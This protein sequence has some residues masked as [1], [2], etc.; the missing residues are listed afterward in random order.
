M[1]SYWLVFIL[2]VG[3]L[4]ACSTP[5][6]SPGHSKLETQSIFTKNQQLG[7]G[8]N[9]GNYLD[10][11]NYEGAWTGGGVI[12]AY[13]F[14]K[15]KTAGFKSI[16][17][18]V[19]WTHHT[20]RNVPYTINETFFKR[21]DWMLDQ[22]TQRG[23]NI[24]VNVHHYDELNASPQGEEARYLAMWQQIANRYKNRGG[25]VY[26]ELLN[27]PHG[28]FNAN[29]ELWNSLLVKALN[30]VRQTNPTRPVIIG[31]AGWNGIE[32]LSRLR[33]PNDPNIIATVHFYSPFNF[34]AQGF[35]GRPRGVNWS[36]TDTFPSWE[37][38]SWN[39][40]LRSV[41]SGKLEVTFQE[42]NAGF[43]LNTS[44]AARNYTSLVINTNQAVSFSVSCSGNNTGQGDSFR[45]LQT[46]ANEET[47]FSLT[48]CSSITNLKMSNTT[49]AAKT[50][51]IS[52]LELRDSTR[53][54]PL[55]TTAGAALQRQLDIAK[56]W[57]DTTGHPIFL[58][59]FG[60]SIYTA[61]NSRVR[62]TSYV[63]SEAEKRGF[64]W[65]Y[66]ALGANYDVFDLS[67]K[68]WNYTLLKALIP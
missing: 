38:W 43:Y 23:L 26:F 7:R 35:D 49:G 27:E 36:S 21:V 18:P 62:W 31:P 47:I 4:V 20:S 67:R 56:R 34:T 60:T 42:A 50:F 5:T 33:L 3:L 14:D 66:W 30:V 55:I 1:R 45:T 39:T 16:R 59:E 12:E 6:S 28:T 68:D 48:G 61:I 58:G 57:S 2:L 44:T 64:S 19:S 65:A 53:R 8:I 46:Q 54:L 40:R 63:R 24:I 25:N 11:D 13:F 29:P 41:S 17:L 52:K 32:W 9:F 15:V 10:A 37:N 22:A 51:V